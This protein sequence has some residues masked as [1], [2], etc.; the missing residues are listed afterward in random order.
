MPI[1][2]IIRAKLV[3]AFEPAELEVINESHLHSG[4]QGSPGTGES[5]FRVKMVAEAFI[6]RSRLERHRMVNEVLAD[7]LAGHVHALAVSARAPG[8][9]ERR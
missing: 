7:E 4:H 2:D 8:E 6:G 1:E 9:L 5:H 3:T